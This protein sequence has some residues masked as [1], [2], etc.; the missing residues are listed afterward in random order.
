MDDVKKIAI[1][2]AQVTLSACDGNPSAIAKVPIFAARIVI[3]KTLVADVIAADQL[4][5]V[6]ITG[7][8]DQKDVTRDELTTEILFGYDV[9]G[10]LADETNDLVLKKEVHFTDSDLG[11]MSGDRLLEVGKN[12]KTKIGVLGIDTL[13]P[14]GYKT[15]DETALNDTL[16]KFETQLNKPE[17][18]IKKHDILVV[19]RNEKYHKMLVYFKNQ[20][21]SAAKPLRKKDPLFYKLYKKCRKLHLQGHRGGGEGE[22]GEFDIVVP[23]SEIVAIPFQVAENKVYMFTDLGNTD[24]VYWTQATPDVPAEIPE[25]NW[26]ITVGAE[27]THNSVELGFPDKIYLFVANESSEVDGEI[28]IDEVI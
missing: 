12:L 8:A 20:L 24:L 17:E 2:S 10:S 14:H 6:N 19:D 28:G 27:A 3:A 18:A 9:I 16:V 5:I 25:E 23:K 21:D 15:E 4:V 26:K 22:P 13:E 11:R 7:I 1:R